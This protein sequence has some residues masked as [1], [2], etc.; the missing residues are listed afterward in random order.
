MER[1]RHV[2]SIVVALGICGLAL[3]AA[4]APASAQA[5][6]DFN[7]DGIADLAIGSPD[8]AVVVGHTPMIG[9]GTVTVIYGSA[10]GLA[11]SS[12]TAVLAPQ[13]LHLDSI[14]GNE[15]FGASLASGDF[16]HDGIAD[17]AVTAP[18]AGVI[19]EFHGSQDGLHPANALLRGV[20]F[21]DAEGLA[22]TLT[23]PLAAADYNAD[24]FDDLA[25]GATEPQGVGRLANL[26]V[27]PGSQ[28]FGLTSVGQKV[29]RVPN[30]GQ[31]GE[32]PDQSVRITLAAGDFSGDGAADLA[33]ALPL[34]DV[35]VTANDGNGGVTMPGTFF[36]AGGIFILQGIPGTGQA[37]GITVDG[38]TT[39]TETNAHFIPQSLEHFGAVLA[40]G[41]FDG[42]GIDDLA[43]G[44]PDEPVIGTTGTLVN[45][46]GFV[47]VFSHATTLHAFY[48]QMPLV[49]NPQ[50]GDHFGAALA[51]GD[52]D[53]D[54]A[55][56]LAI[57]T[58][59]DV[60]GG[61]AGAGSVNVIYG[62]VGVGLPRPAALG[63][64]AINGRVQ[65]F[66]QS[67][68][69]IADTPETGDHFGA[70]LT[71]FNFGRSAH[72]DLAIG[73]PDEDML[74]S[75]GLNP[76][77]GIFLLANIVDA[78]AVEVIYGTATGL[79]AAGSVLWSENSSGVP[80]T[81]DDSDRFGSSLP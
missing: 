78:G 19:Q 61:V 76:T 35:T 27:R 49:Q 18:G 68:T 42:D 75:R 36:D 40:V 41:D 29:F 63:L 64:P 50:A 59:N 73:V 45:G 33:V 37:G 30:S 16:N 4:A 77:I 34:A 52:F 17:L 66:T 3:A 69:D 21:H 32:T 11:A 2:R 28:Q 62:I 10:N 79:Q 14:N 55:D 54:G 74:V 44:T 12:T 43:V 56:D 13:L 7:G 71:A 58:P 65:L 22:L 72:D 60:I 25:I 6:A 31:A 8:E 48:T 46:G 38:F 23:G 20:N 81:A 5:R 57:G 26:I 70:S 53:G 39:L 51:A 80:G 24:G 67:T 47:A 9:S 15:H 1:T